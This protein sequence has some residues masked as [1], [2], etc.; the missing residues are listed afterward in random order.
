MRSWHW[1]GWSTLGSS[2]AS[3]AYRQGRPPTARRSIVLALITLTSM[4][5]VGVAPVGTAGATGFTPTG[6]GV[7]AIASAGG[8]DPSGSSCACVGIDSSTKSTVNLATGDF[9][10]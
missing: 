9:W 8:S 10:L 6:G 1:Q 2:S 7:P 5:G 4:I 3:D